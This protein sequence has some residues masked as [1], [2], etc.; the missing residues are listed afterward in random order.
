MTNPYD[1]QHPSET[2]G[3]IAGSM[4]N[5]SD[6]SPGTVYALRSSSIFDANTFQLHQ[7][8]QARLFYNQHPFRG[9]V[10]G[11]AWKKQEYFFLYEGERGRMTPLY[12]CV[13][14][15][16]LKHLDNLSLSQR[17]FVTTA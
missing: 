13:A 15:L 6:R 2:G 1:A 7:E 10:G 17:M 8:K 3:T 16:L 4:K 5:R 14:T 11:Y 12:A 9:P